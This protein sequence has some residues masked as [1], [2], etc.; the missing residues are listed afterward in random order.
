MPDPTMLLLHLQF[1]SHQWWHVCVTLAA[2]TTAGMLIDGRELRSQLGCPVS[3]GLSS[4]S[5]S[6]SAVSSVSPW[7]TSPSVLS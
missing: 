2:I 6:A 7:D 1:H 4:T 3:A 5:W